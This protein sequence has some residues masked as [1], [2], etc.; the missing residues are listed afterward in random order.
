MVREGKHVIR[1]DHGLCWGLSTRNQRMGDSQMHMVKLFAVLGALMFS[2]LASAQAT[3][4]CG[5][6]ACPGANPWNLAVVYAGTT[7]SEITGINDLKVGGNLFDVSF[8]ATAPTSSPFV[9][10][11]TTAAAGQPLTGV[12]AGNSIS[13][14][15]GALLP[16]YSNGYG[17]A[18]DPGAAFITAFAPAGSMSTNYFGATEL[19]DVA[20][21]SV[22]GGAV[23][24]KVFGNN[25]FSANGQSIVDNN[26]NQIFYTKWTPI[27]APEIDPVSTTSALALLF[28]GLAVLRGRRP[29]QRSA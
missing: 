19:W 24:T 10:S 6:V 26:G 23:P 1:P 3:F 18:G 29:A 2:S 21:T 5:S 28:G 20:E 14:F 8:T 13:A 16:P 11:Q 22:G 9:L 12:N 17:I 4:E 25:G 7:A 27:A 15:F